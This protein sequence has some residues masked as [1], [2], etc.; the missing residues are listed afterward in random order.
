ML[1]VGHAESVW[2]QRL[3]AC[4][5]WAAWLVLGLALGALVDAAVRVALASRFDVSAPETRSQHGP[6]D[7]QAWQRVGNQVMTG[8]AG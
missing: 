1:F 3:R 8:E 2:M 4:A 6:T 7:G 5:Y